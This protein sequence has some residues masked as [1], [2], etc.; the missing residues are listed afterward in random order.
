MTATSARIGFVLEPY[1]RAVAETAGT[2]ARHGNLARETSDPIESWFAAVA[3]AQTRADAR[4]A[5]LSVD[6]RMFEVK[7]SGRDAETVLGLLSYTTVPL[8]RYVD[9]ERDLDMPVIIASATVDIE[10]QSASLK[11]WG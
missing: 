9:E 7:I 10:S 1:R 11:V 3:D 6:R 8:A 5:L 2:A 4:Q